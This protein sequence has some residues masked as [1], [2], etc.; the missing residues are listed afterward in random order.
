[1][2]RTLTVNEARP[3]EAVAAVVDGVAL[4]AAVVVAAASVVAV[5]VAVAATAIATAAVAAAGAGNPPAFLDM[6]T[7]R[8]HWRPPGLSA[9]K[10]LAKLTPTG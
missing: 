7:G 2:G 10:C 1:M 8:S 3:R 9:G 4:A 5:V 6:R